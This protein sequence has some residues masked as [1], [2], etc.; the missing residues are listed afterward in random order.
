ME[1][2]NQRY[3]ETTPYKNMTTGVNMRIEQILPTSWQM[4]QKTRMGKARGEYTIGKN[5]KHYREYC[6]YG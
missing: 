3:S 6:T 2:W 1:L 5:M 4:S